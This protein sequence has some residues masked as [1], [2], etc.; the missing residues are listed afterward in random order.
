[1][2]TV[3]NVLLIVEYEDKTKTIEFINERKLTYAYTNQTR[4][5]VTLAF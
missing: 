3:E 5:A 4:C 2:P 1:M